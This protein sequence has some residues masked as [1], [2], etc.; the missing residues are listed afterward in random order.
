MYGLSMRIIVYNG[1]KVGQVRGT[2]KFTCN[3]GVSP[4][5]LA[6]NIP[7]DDGKWHHVVVTSD[8]PN[9]IAKLYVDG[10]L[11]VSGSSANLLSGP[12]LT[13]A[14]GGAA[15]LAGSGG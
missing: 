4:T 9:S 7:V 14:F 1:A 12:G 13:M 11:D 2:V 6:G 5:T 3:N 8:N 15:N 10:V